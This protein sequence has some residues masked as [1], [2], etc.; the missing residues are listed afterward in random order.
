[1]Y[2]ND[3]IVLNKDCF[4]SRYV[5]KINEFAA[6]IQSDWAKHWVLEGAIMYQLYY[7]WSDKCTI[8]STINEVYIYCWNHGCTASSFWN[9]TKLNFLYMTRAIIDSLIVWFEGVPTNKLEEK[10]KWN[11]LSR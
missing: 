10:D 5:T 8:D 4:G 1:M 7:M 6:M 2:K 9:N 11:T 3:S